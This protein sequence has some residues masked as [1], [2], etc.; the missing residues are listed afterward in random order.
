[1]IAGNWIFEG[2][3]CGAG[4]IGYITINAVRQ[5]L[6]YKTKSRVSRE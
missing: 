1:V 6:E 3:E 4:R 5:S 2:R